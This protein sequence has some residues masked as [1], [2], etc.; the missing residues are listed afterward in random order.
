MVVSQLPSGPFILVLD[1][2]INFFLFWG[3]RYSGADED[4]GTDIL[5]L[6]KFW[7]RCSG[8][9]EDLLCWCPCFFWVPP[10][11]RIKYIGVNR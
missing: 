6:I 4:F 7:Y 5:V 11:D 8:T 9:Y 10:K 1:R 2:S 3:Y